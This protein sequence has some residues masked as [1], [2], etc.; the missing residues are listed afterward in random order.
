MDDAKLKDH[1]TN[2]VNRISD[3]ETK[4]LSVVS[5]VNE[6]TDTKIAALQLAIETKITEE[7][8]RCIT[9]IQ[10]S[11]NELSSDLTGGEGSVTSNLS[12]FKS[13]MET[14][15]TSS[16]DRIV[17]E[18]DSDS[19]LRVE[20]SNLTTRVDNT[21]KT[22]VDEIKAKSDIVVDKVETV[23]AKSTENSV[24]LS[25]V[26]ESVAAGNNKVAGLDGISSTLN[27]T[28]TELKSS[29]QHN[30]TS[31]ESVLSGQSNIATDVKNCKDETESVVREVLTQISSKHAVVVSKLSDVLLQVTKSE[32]A[33]VLKLQSEIQRLEIIF[34]TFDKLLEFPSLIDKHFNDYYQI[35]TTATSALIDWSIESKSVDIKTSDALKEINVSLAL[36]GQLDG[37]LG[38]KMTIITRHLESLSAVC[39]AFATQVKI[40]EKQE[41]L[42]KMKLISEIAANFSKTGESAASIVDM[43]KPEKEKII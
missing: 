1:F 36:I 7:A 21:K 43:L 38:E 2:T 40:E 39:G 33:L 10:D 5:L 34:H 37:N 20:L 22:V 23:L 35:I 18:F 12:N 26:A 31:F 13:E 9:S 24:A 29:K 27:E 15:I 32:G 25:S 14:L 28:L 6:H 41:D 16:R 4:I 42:E 30:K 19:T 8:N 3:M 17:S 11:K